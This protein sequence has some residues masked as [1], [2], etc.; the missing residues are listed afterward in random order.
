MSRAKRIFWLVTLLLFTGGCSSY[1]AVSPPRVGD[2]GW[3]SAVRVG[4]QVSITLTDD[5]KVEGKVLAISSEALTLDGIETTDYTKYPENLSGDY[6]PRV[7]AFDS[8]RI[9]EKSH[10]SAGKTTLLISGIIVGALALLAVLVAASGGIS[11]G[12]SGQ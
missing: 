2:D 10:P 6:R 4:D 5:G 9:L 12:W 11:A 1:K 8:I 7:I 3:E